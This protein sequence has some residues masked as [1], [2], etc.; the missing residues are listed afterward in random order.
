[1]SIHS[2]TDYYANILEDY[3]KYYLIENYFIWL[4][5]NYCAMDF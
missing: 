2:H 3:V 5:V 1:M 4:N